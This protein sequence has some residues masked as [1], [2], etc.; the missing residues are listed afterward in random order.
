MYVVQKKLYIGTLVVGIY[1]L[2]YADNYAD[3]ETL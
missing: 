2:Q 1:I 3:L